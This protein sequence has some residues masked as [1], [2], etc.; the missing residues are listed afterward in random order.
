MQDFNSS[1][2]R[3]RLIFSNSPL[4]LAVA[5]RLVTW[6]EWSHVGLILDDGR[7]ID[8]T[9]S[10]HGVRI[11]SLDDFK[12]ASREWTIVELPVNDAREVYRAAVSQLDRP[13]DITGLFGVLF[14]NHRWNEDD[15]WFCSEL[16][17]YA[18]LHS[19]NPIVPANFVGRVT[20]QRVW[21]HPH[22]IITSGYGNA[23]LLH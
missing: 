14:N 6:S 13:Y 22:R 8:A 7:V 2:R 18:M 11:R 20:P 4:P 21:M 9:Y 5:I 15:S 17:A 1:K 23:G 12:K 3:I 19:G 10:H 16:V